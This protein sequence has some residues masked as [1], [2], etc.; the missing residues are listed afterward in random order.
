M[1]IL[2]RTT[3]PKKKTVL[4]TNQLSNLVI[5]KKKTVLKIKSLR[6]L[7]EDAHRVLR[8]PSPLHKTPKVSKKGTSNKQKAI[9]KP[10]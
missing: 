10:T 8:L 7:K 2:N 5:P 4:K 3:A 6:K 1:R 9:K